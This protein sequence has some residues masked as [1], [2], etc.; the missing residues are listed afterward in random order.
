MRA[1][2]VTGVFDAPYPV[3]LDLVGRRALV[4]GGGPVAAHKVAGLLRAGAHVTVVAPDAVSEIAEDPD[5]RWHERPY[6]RGEV[7]SYTIAITAT[8]DPAVNR[9]VARDGNAAN[10]WVNSADDPKNC[11]FILP[12]VVR[13][14]DLQV[15]VSTN[16]RSP[17]MAQ[18]ARR[19]LEDLFTEAHGAALDVLAEVRAEV[20]RV[21][22]TSEVGGWAAVV[23]DHF[24]DLI[25]A[26][27]LDRARA[28]LRA[29]LDLPD[30][31]S[32]APQPS[33]PQHDSPHQEVP[34]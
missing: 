26:G 25:A 33:S 21:H 4:V 8:N 17:A 5:V 27:D 18:W 16:G 22:G 12:S 3:F 19:R 14:G 7:A 6:R 11:A 20:Q 15:A 9:Q 23:D 34:S 1:A 2:P 13:R 24:F 28:Q 30:V 29:G 32:D 10:V 31:P